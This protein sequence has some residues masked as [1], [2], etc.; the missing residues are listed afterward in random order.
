MGGAIGTDG[1]VAAVP[2]LSEVRLN[3]VFVRFSNNECISETTWRPLLAEAQSALGKQ[4]KNKFCRT[5][6]GLSEPLPKLCHNKGWAQLTETL[7]VNR[8]VS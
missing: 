8:L 5:R 4:T 2:L 7:S 3:T 1:A 6:I